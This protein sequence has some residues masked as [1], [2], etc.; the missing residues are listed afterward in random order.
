MKNFKEICT[1]IKEMYHKWHDLRFFTGSQG[2]S[3]LP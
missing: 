2:S 3:I 1:D